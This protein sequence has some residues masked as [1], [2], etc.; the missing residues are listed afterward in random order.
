M[1]EENQEVAPELEATK[2][3]V[4]IKEP[5]VDEAKEGDND[6]PDPAPQTE[7][8]GAAEP[9][10]PAKP[11]SRHQRRRE[12]MD[13]L[14]SQIEEKDKALAEVNARLQDIEGYSACCPKGRRL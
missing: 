5:Q 7:P 1:A 13:R 4:S 9:E 10:E 3:D 2:E 8:K 14:Q 11:K 12:Q 6:T